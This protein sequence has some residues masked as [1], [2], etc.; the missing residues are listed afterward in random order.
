M[1]AN[2]PPNKESTHLSRVELVKKAAPAGYENAGELAV[3]E[4]RFG[5]PSLDVNRVRMDLSL[6]DWIPQETAMQHMMLPVEGDS[7]NLT[8]VMAN[9]GNRSAIEE[10]E[11]VTGKNISAWVAPE[12]SVQSL[13]KQAYAAQRQGE[14]WLTGP[15]YEQEV[16]VIPD[17]FFGGEPRLDSTLPLS[18]IEKLNGRV[19]VVEDDAAIRKMLVVH[20]ERLGLLVTQAQDGQEA[21]DCLSI[22]VPDLAIIDAMLPKVHGFEVIKHIRAMQTEKPVEIIVLTAVHRGWRMAEDL[23]VTAGVK[24]YI[25]KPFAASRLLE[26]VASVLGSGANGDGQPT[27]NTELGKAVALLK[28]GRPSEAV[29]VLK[30]ALEKEPGSHLLHYHLGLAYERQGQVF[31]AIAAIEHAVALMPRYFVGVKNLAVLYHRVGFQSKSTEMWERAVV[32]APEDKTREAI[33]SHLQ[34]LQ[35]SPG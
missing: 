16:A 33:R 17:L 27:A 21:I 32:L 15:S 29:N 6:L 28:A 10:F 13:I 35:I 2:R 7:R 5:V 34:R 25:E 4:K 12:A 14:K 3:L 24:H 18:G 30:S 8:V 1:S 19:L 31:E 23:R 22:A 20:L 26:A 9:P 11:F